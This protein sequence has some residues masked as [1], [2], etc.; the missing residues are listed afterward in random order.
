M[1]LA[2][3]SATASVSLSRLLPGLSAN[4]QKAAARLPFIVGRLAMA[5]A[6]HGS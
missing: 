3:V 6:A 4:V 2:P 1:T 5:L